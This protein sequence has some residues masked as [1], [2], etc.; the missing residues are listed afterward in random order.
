MKK[1]KIG[2]KII[3]MFLIIFVSMFYMQNYILATDF[4]FDTMKGQA[5]SFISEGKDGSTINLDN[6]QNIVISVTQI[7]VGV[8]SVVL[9]IVTMV[10]GVTYMMGTPEKKSE[11]K[12]KLIGLVVSVCVVFGAQLIWSIVYNIMKDVTGG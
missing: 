7:L 9:L 11:L 10:M 12:S 6:A 3:T 2:I 5:D 1:E 8:A 4:S